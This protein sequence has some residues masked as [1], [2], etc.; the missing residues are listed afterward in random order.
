MN[1]DPQENPQENPQETLEFLDLAILCK[2]CYD[3]RHTQIYKPEKEEENTFKKISRT[4]FY[5]RSDLINTQAISTISI[6][7]KI[8]IITFAG[9]NDVFDFAH[10]INVKQV[11]PEF[12]EDGIKFHL[13]FL[14]QFRSLL[15]NVYKTLEKFINE[16]GEKIIFSGHSTGGCIASIF[17]YYFKIV[18]KSDISKNFKDL[19]VVTFGS[20]MFTNEIGSLWFDTNIIYTRIQLDKDPIPKLPILSGAS[21]YGPSYYHVNKTLIYIKNEKIL[22]NPSKDITYLNCFMF[23]KKLFGKTINLENHH[24][25]KYIANLEKIKLQSL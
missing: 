9:S 15:S 22:L 6:D 20:P 25:K 19:E 1:Q 24:I 8:I 2:I 18:Y 23:I 5:I 7:K 10:N 4:I 11:D 16:N 17:A 13:G 14:N 3:V 12:C 21:K